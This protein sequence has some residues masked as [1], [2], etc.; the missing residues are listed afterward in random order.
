MTLLQQIIT[1]AQASLSFHFIQNI[2]L[3]IY[4]F[5]YCKMIQFAVLM[6]FAKGMAHLCFLCVCVCALFQALNCVCVS[7]CYPQG[8]GCF[9][10]G[11]GGD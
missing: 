6:F 9:P 2:K 5:Q 7:V 11:L 1:T 3:L 4:F 10:L 8:W